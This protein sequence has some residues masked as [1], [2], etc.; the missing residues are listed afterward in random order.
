MMGAFG[1]ALQLHHLPEALSTSEVVRHDEHG[2]AAIAHHHAVEQADGLRHLARREVVAFGK[3]LTK[4]GAGIGVAQSV[5][6]LHHSELGEGGRVEPILLVIAA[7]DEAEGA[8]WAAQPY[9]V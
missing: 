1:I 7:A 9:W 3:R 2:A 8:H 4:L 5:F 6:A